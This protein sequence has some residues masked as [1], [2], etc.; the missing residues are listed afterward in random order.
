MGS[1][2]SR[3]LT[4]PVSWIR[5]AYKSIFRETS[6]AW[7]N[8]MAKRGPSPGLTETSGLRSKR[9][10]YMV[11]FSD[12]RRLVQ[13]KYTI[14]QSSVEKLYFNRKYPNEHNGQIAANNKFL[15]FIEF[16]ERIELIFLASILLSQKI[17]FVLFFFR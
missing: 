1:A 10:T 7:E 9:S 11:L 8:L 12:H 3:S 2:E 14:A 17:F 6:N 15:K 16:C 4:S 13:S 5:K